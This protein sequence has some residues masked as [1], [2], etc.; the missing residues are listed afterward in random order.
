M[1]VRI[2]DNVEITT[3]YHRQFVYRADPRD[4]GFGFECDE[5]GNVDVASLKPLAAANYQKCIEG[6][7]DVVDVGVDVTE[8]RVQPCHCG[9]GLQPEDIHDGKGIYLC[10]A[11]D[12]CKPDKLKG[13]RSDIFSDY[14]TD[15]QVDEDY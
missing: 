15:E 14:E 3:T 9:S 6:E 13:Y 4:G 8:I 10:R 5:H 11:C 7:F 2:E 1:P 12:K